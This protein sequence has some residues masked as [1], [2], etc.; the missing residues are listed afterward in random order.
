MLAHENPFRSERV[1]AL[2][3]RPQGDTWP[4]IMARLKALRFRGAIVGPKGTGKTTM[5]LELKSRLQAEGWKAESMRLNEAC[6]VPDAQRMRRIV[7]EAGRETI[8][9][10]DGAERLGPAAWLQFQWK[11]RRAGGLVITTHRPGRLATLHATRTSEA[12]L[13]EL[14]MVLHDA[15]SNSADRADVFRSHKGNLREVFF[16]YFR[17]AAG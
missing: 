3:F 2:A 17:R 6:R 16:E 7:R 1:E 10:L 12:L 15:A 9:L 14:L 8:V 5:L 4:E 11:T 13:D